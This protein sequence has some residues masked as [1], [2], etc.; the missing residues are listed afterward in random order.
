MTAWTKVEVA[1]REN[2]VNLGCI[3]EVGKLKDLLMDF[4]CRGVREKNKNQ[5][6]LHNFSVGNRVDNDAIHWSGEWRWGEIKPYVTN[7]RGRLNDQGGS[8]LCILELRR[9]YEAG[10]TFI[11]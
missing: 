10:D 3:L 2:L 6:W 4:I 1:D 9:R 5:A 8:G 11:V 7:G